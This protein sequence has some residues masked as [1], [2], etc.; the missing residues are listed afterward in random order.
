MKKFINNLS[1]WIVNHKVIIVCVFVLL[2]ALSVVGN[3][4][5]K[6]ESDVISYL[7]E[8]TQTIQ[9]LTTLRE[10]YGII[11]DFSIAI[12]HLSKEQVADILSVI[13]SD[14]FLQKDGNYVKDKNG[15]YEKVAGLEGKTYRYVNEDNI[16]T[17][18][19][20]STYLNKVVWFGTFDQLSRLE[21]L[22]V[23][24]AE[25]YDKT[26]STLQNKFVVEKDGVQTYIISFYFKTASSADETISSIDKIEEILNE[27]ISGYIADG[28]LN[29]PYSD[30]SSYFSFGGSAENSRSIL[31][32]SLGDMPKFVIAAVLCVFVILFLTTNSYLEPLIF[33]AT[34]GIS[35]LLNM[36]TNIIA[37][38]P[39]G[40]ISTITSSC[41][42][43]LQ[44][45]IA[46]DYSIFLMHTYY[47]EKR[48][49]PNPQIAM[50]N[51]LPK[52][53][54][55]IASSTLTTVGG[56]VALFF[57][58]F[59]I[60]YDLG[61]VLAKGVILAL[62]SVLFMQPIITLIFNKLLDKTYHKW[63]I[64]P[65]LKFISKNITKLPIS[66]VVVVLCIAVLIPSAMFQSKVPLSYIS[67][68]AEIENPTLADQ[69][70]IAQNNQL[71]VIVPAE[72]KNYDKQFQFIEEVKKIGYTDAELTQKDNSYNN[73]SDVFSLCTV[74][75][76]ETL[77]NVDNSSLTYV[78]YGL[79]HKSFISDLAT[80]NILNE[81]GSV[82]QTVEEQNLAADH[83]MLYTI[84]IDGDK[85]APESYNTMLKVIE[86][87]NNIFGENSLKITGNAV[88][89]YDLSNITPKDYK[90][91][92]ILSVAIIFIILLFTFK[93]LLTSAILVGVIETGIWA[94]LTITYLIGKPINFMAYLIVTAIL[95]G[96]TVD[97]AILVTSKYEDEKKNGVA[98][99]SAIKNAI[100]RAAPSV[101]T[102]GSIFVVACI[103][104]NLISTNIIVQQITEILA[105]GAAI[106]VVLVFT[107]LPSILS[108][109]ERLFRQISIKR[110]KGD[111]DEGKSTESIYAV[112]SK[113]LKEKQ[114]EMGIIEDSQN[115]D[116]SAVEDKK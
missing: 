72:Y 4:F 30:S 59:G 55:S 90:L 2:L 54:I 34:L 43:I 19:T 103:M 51:A 104:V 74:L 13:Q 28:T 91:V 18:K 65:R 109:K 83:F 22:G 26:V 38:K 96:A 64:T 81:D 35:I 106:S 39:M 3:M 48:K 112:S 7:D 61:F 115:T 108:L 17:Y 27:K 36:G 53:V 42:T 86:I 76:K 31:K 77:N 88:G 98:S 8:D 50:Q 70:L 102:S 47:E 41:A 82:A 113:L 93:S 9:G 20:I 80:S 10:E 116:I 40:T 14:E 69:V 16:K 63:I 95:L 44:L 21:S 85:E 71:I 99:Q 84:T 100:Y 33:L 94:N 60:G 32:S 68:T 1:K 37:G 46:M 66:I 11:G 25:N 57:M 24:T 58:S 56:F 107:L 52:A 5:V 87:G 79:L 105:R 73:I 15:Y 75:D 89:S 92:S 114:E 62:L 67:T 23:I 110:G 6:K 45:A 12:S 101:L 78:V 29:G 49:T 111:P 97:Y